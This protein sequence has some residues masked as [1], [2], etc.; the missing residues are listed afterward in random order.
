MLLSLLQEEVTFFEINFII[1]KFIGHEV[2]Y[3]I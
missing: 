3:E 1:N 2:K